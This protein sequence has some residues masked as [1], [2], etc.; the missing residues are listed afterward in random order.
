MRGEGGSWDWCM[1]TPSFELWTKLFYCIQ[2][3]KSRLYI[4]TVSRYWSSRF[5]PKLRTVNPREIIFKSTNIQRTVYIWSLFKAQKIYGAPMKPS[6]LF[7]FQDKKFRGVI[8]IFL[9]DMQQKIPAGKLY[10]AIR[11]CWECKCK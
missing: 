6:Q 8:I 11:I 7:C 4:A 10:A 3:L 1:C 9:S 5:S 2:N